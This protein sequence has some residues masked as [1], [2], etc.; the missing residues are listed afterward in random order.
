MIPHSH[1]DVDSSEGEACLFASEL[2]TPAFFRCELLNVPLGDLPHALDIA[3]ADIHICNKLK[4]RPHG[5]CVPFMDLD[6]LRL[7]LTHMELT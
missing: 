3:V 2:G 6:R 1:V 5:H 4:L 7:A